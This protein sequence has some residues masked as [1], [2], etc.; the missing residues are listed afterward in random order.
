MWQPGRMPDSSTPGLKA[1]NRSRVIERIYR[2]LDALRSLAVVAFASEATLDGFNAAAYGTAGRYDP[3]SEAYVSSLYPWEE[4]AI[5]RHFPPPPA[6]ILVGGAGAG[7][8]PFALAELGYEVAAFEPVGRLAEAM[9]ERAAATGAAVASYRGG[10]RDLP[11]LQ[12]VGA[13]RAQTL[14]PGFD[15]AVIGWGSISHL[16]TESDRVGA[17]Q[18]MAELTNGPILVSFIA[19]RP[20]GPLRVSRM[21]T[22]LV[23]RR[24]RHPA[25]RFSISMG[26]HH[27]VNEAEV[28][29]L[30]ATARLEVAAVDFSPTSLAP[31]AVL[32]A[33]ERRDFAPS[34]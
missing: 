2:R 33:A 10:Y 18:S 24:G 15:A 23:S 28:R 11:R 21:R 30:A 6:R 25:D 32:Q 26:F 13:A 4:A 14:V 5:E 22:W 29:E 12:P 8:E 19:V 27:P 7:R 20:D 31:H 34:P 17:L 3:D 1:I 9:A 16:Y